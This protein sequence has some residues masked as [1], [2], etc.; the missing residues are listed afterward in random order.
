M[1]I[2]FPE[3]LGLLTILITAVIGFA[4]SLRV[5]SKEVRALSKDLCDMQERLA[6]M[7]EKFEHCQTELQQCQRQLEQQIAARGSF[8]RALLPRAS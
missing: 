3:F 7:A 5:L 6:V 2:S 1:T 4:S 8:W